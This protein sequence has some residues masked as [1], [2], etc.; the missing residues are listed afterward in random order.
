ML[1][2]FTDEVLCRFDQQL[3]KAKEKEK[4]KLIPFD[5]QRALAGDK[6]ITRV[7]RKIIDIA[8]FK[9]SREC[10]RIYAQLEDHTA[11]YPHFEDG[12]WCNTQESDRD[13][14][15][16]PKTKTYWANVYENIYGA[17]GLGL[18]YATEEIAKS[19]QSSESHIKTISFEVEE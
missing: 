12:K 1:F 11:P 9:Y 18:V 19:N 15:M 3:K 5:L 17:P 2:N 13:L 4:M 7:G 14:F 8:Y 6:V 16:A 10:S